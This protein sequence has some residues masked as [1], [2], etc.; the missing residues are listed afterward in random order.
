MH[1]REYQGECQEVT[2][3]NVQSTM[4]FA[5]RESQGPAQRA[6]TVSGTGLVSIYDLILPTS[7]GF[8]KSSKTDTM[9]LLQHLQNGY[10]AGKPEAW[11]R[12]EERIV[13]RLPPIIDRNCPL[14]EWE[15]GLA[16]IEILLLSG[17]SPECFAH[18]AHGWGQD[19]DFRIF[20]TQLIREYASA[21]SVR[22][23]MT[24][25][26]TDSQPMGLSWVQ[27]KALMGEDV[28]DFSAAPKFDILEQEMESLTK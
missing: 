7:I 23:T 21:Q 22:A 24:R 16:W 18:W 17:S 13:R 9:P 15:R 28:L 6:T 26:S 2:A 14:E 27:E 12:T 20:L 4:P 10:L 25:P 5:Q 8:F 1:Y 19:G 3:V 11:H